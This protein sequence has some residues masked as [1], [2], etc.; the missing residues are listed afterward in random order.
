MKEPVKE[1][2]ITGRFGQIGD[3]GQKERLFDL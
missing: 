3:V 2:D 1:K